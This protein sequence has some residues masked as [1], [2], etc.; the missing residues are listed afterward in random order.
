MSD[1]NTE[2]STTSSRNINNQNEPTTT[3]KSTTSGGDEL[4]LLQT[5]QQWVRTLD[6]NDLQ[7]YL[8]FCVRG[9]GSSKNAKQQNHPSQHRLKHRDEYD[10]IQDM[11]RL[12]LPLPTPIHPRAVP[13]EPASCMGRNY[14][15]EK[16][17]GATTGIK[18]KTRRW[19]QF[20]SNTNRDDVDESAEE[21]LW[22]MLQQNTIFVVQ[23]QRI[24]IVSL[25]I[26]II[27]RRS[28]NPVVVQIKRT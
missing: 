5:F 28:T 21:K 13:Y 15:E 1:H 22:E 9:K 14:C 8:I 4:L 2:S 3:S 20:I 19:L 17:T 16:N 7:N 10:M 27:K 11:V 18:V 12:Q 26:M 25:K 24:Q 6:W 23:H